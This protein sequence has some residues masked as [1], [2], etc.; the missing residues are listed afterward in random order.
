M[1]IGHSS[2]GP[3]VISGTQEGKETVSPVQK[4]AELVSSLTEFDKA[5]QA[6]DL[7]YMARDEIVLCLI[8]PVGVGKTQAVYASAEKRGAKVVEIIASQILPNEVSGITMP[9]AETKSMQ[10]Y[11][12]ARL[13]SLQ[14]G[15]VLFFDELL[16]ADQ[17]VL[18]AC[19]TLIQ[20]RRLMSGKRLPDIQIVAACNPTQSPQV[21]KASIRQRFLF[22]EYVLDSTDVNRYMKKKYPMLPEFYLDDLVA[23]VKTSDNNRYNILTPRSLDKMLYWITSANGWEYRYAIAKEADDLFSTNLF[24]Q[25]VKHWNAAED[26][27][28]QKESR[29]KQD[30]AV[31]DEVI[32][33]F[34]D[35]KDK[36]SACESISEVFNVLQQEANWDDIKSQLESIDVQSVLE[37]V[38]ECSGN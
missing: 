32:N 6:I 17:S 16:E 5:V 31:M 23:S 24:D 19:L 12:H 10:I 7:A 34:P 13:S 3:I 21:L 25:L 33:R 38:S 14:D 18:S 4:G 28:E 37:G 27:M 9:E 26:Q 35:L 30:K 1:L 8:G 11:D 22:H 15:D 29:L 36:L 2:F 20:E